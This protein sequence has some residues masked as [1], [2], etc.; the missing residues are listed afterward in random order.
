M[1]TE[2]KDTKSS[3]KSVGNVTVVHSKG[4]IV[5]DGKEEEYNTIHVTRQKYK[6]D[7]DKPVVKIKV[8]REIA[9]AILA[10]EKERL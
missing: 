6:D 4:I 2:F 10:A 8:N 7:A 3:S 5:K 1:A 9:E